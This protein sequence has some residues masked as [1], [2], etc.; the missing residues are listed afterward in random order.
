MALNILVFLKAI[1]EDVKEDPRT[2]GPTVEGVKLKMDDISRNAVEEAIRLKE[3]HGGRATGITFGSDAATLVMKE[4]LAMGLDEGVLIKGYAGNNPSLTASVLAERVSRMQW[5]L[6]MFGFSSAD[7]YTAQVPPMVSYM[8]KRPLIGNAVS[9]RVEGKTVKGVSSYEDYNVAY[10]A[11]MP[12]VISVAQ[13]INTPRIP[14]LLQIMAASKKPLSVEQAQAQSARTLQ[15]LG[16]TFP[17]SQRKRII[18]ED[19]NKGVEEVA[20]V[21]RQV[22]GK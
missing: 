8:L 4:A 11:E 6:L 5:D 22:L 19:T 7:S 15:V 20:A 10:E 2:H 12:A 3:K 17:M 18:F 9:L 14:T 1:P 16:H 13:E 21:L